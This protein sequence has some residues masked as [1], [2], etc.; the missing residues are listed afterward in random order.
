MMTSDPVA[1][2]SGR[3]PSLTSAELGTGSRGLQGS[4]R[5]TVTVTVRQL[6]E[7]VRGE[8]L[9][10]GDQLI[11]S[12]RPLGGSPT[13]RH[14]LRR[15]REAPDRLACLPCHG[16]DRPARSSRQRPPA[17]P[18]RRPPHGIRAGCPASSRQAGRLGTRYQ[19]DGPDPPQ[20][21]VGLRSQRSD[22]W[23]SS[24]RGPRL[25][26]NCTIHARVSIGRFCKLGRDV[27]LHPHVVLYD[28]SR[29]R[30][31]SD[32]STRMR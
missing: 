31:S 8:L 4:M 2:A 12:A 15:G 18:R 14:H 27:T 17:H 23:Q 9:G 24:E 20:R 22:P 11:S 21:Q 28:D 13:W 19:P 7:C 10:D 5:P 29:T 32:R 3:T 26:D 30:Q 6:A 1:L 16:R 25:A